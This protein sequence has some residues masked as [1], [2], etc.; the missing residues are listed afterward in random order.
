[1]TRSEP[2]SDLRSRVRRSTLRLLCWTVAWLLTTALL[3]FGPKFIWNEALGATLLALALN[4]G[5]GLGVILANRQHLR[6]LDEMIQKVLL[7]AMGITLG[8]VLVI[9]I[10]YSL[11]DAYD[12]FAFEADI[13]HLYFVMG[14]T[15][16]ASVVVGMR[17]Y[18]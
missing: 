6:D 12:V 10:P 4:L 7:E 15:L 9:G 18:R 8:V 3:A 16:I 2:D 14:L 1:M 17:R 5:A 11:L 13:A